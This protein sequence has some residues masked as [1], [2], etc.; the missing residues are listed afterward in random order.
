VKTSS[1]WEK[2][3]KTSQNPLILILFRIQ[4]TEQEKYTKPVT[5]S[6]DEDGRPLQVAKVGRKPAYRP[7]NKTKVVQV[8]RCCAGF[9]KT[10]KNECEGCSFSL[11]H[12]KMAELICKQNKNLFHKL[13][14]VKV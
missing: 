3:V 2:N 4:F 13:K 7:V 6:R 9:S 5:M 12:R 10:V 14:N 1:K 8:R 11:N